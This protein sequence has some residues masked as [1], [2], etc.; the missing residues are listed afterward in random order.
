MNYM[1]YY[2]RRIR[3]SSKTTCRIEI[4]IDSIVMKDFAWLPQKDYADLYSIASQV[5]WDCE[6]SYDGS[7]N[8]NFHKF[9]MDCL[10]RKVKTYITHLNRDRRKANII[11]ESIYQQINEESSK[12]LEDTIE[13]FAT[14]NIDDRVEANE[15]LEEIYKILKPKERKYIELTLLGYDNKTIADKLNL[16]IKYV[17]GINKRLTQQSDIRRIARI[18]GYLGGKDDEV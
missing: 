3:S 5:L 4:M 14:I 9:L 13:D 18:Y 1:D 7:K 11:A 8:N 6:K 12:T 10:K 2:L 15:V 16:S 17:N